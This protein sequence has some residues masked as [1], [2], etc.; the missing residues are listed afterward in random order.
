MNIVN[1][2]PLTSLNSLISL[3]THSTQSAPA[4][5]STQ[6]YPETQLLRQE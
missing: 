3:I 1:I 4:Y 5:G 6:H 2:P